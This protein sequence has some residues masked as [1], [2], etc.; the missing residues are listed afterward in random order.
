VAVD[1]PMRWRRIGLTAESIFSPA[2]RDNEVELEFELNLALFH[3]EQTK[4]WV[5]ARRRA[6]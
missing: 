4:A 1:V 6:V 3:K 2:S 5:S